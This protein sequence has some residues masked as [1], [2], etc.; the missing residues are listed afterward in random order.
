MLGGIVNFALLLEVMADVTR[1]PMRLGTPD[2]SRLAAG[3]V[4]GV[5]AVVDR[6]GR[7]NAPG[8]GG[9]SPNVFER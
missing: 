5:I 3:L 1:P 7:E 6:E 9:L 8:R 4:R 2:R